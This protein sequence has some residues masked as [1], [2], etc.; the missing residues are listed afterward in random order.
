[1]AL[2]SSEGIGA[3]EKGMDGAAEA[4]LLA[5][6]EQHLRN[7]E[8]APATIINYIADVRKVL[9]WLSQTKGVSFPA[10]GLNSQDLRQ[11]CIYLLKVE[12]H[13]GT[14]VSRYLCSIGRFCRFVLAIGV[15]APNKGIRIE[16]PRQ[17]KHILP[18]ALNWEEVQRLLQAART[19][20]SISA[21]RDYAI[22]QVLLQTG[23]RVGE[24][25]DMRMG[26][27]CISERQARVSVNR[28]RGGEKREIPLNASACRA[29]SEYLAVRTPVPGVEHVFL[30]RDGRPFS[31]RSVQRIVSYY[32]GRAGL[33]GVSAKTL[34]YTCAKHLL[35]ETGDLALISRLLGYSRIESAARYGIWRRDDAAQVMENSSLNIF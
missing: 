31:T 35:E 24:L 21:E 33:D 32:A 20:S 22:M 1:M 17:P 7:A 19:E 6:F 12:E 18:R 4:K 2:S 23:M 30:T 26:D 13:T 25:S 16:L 5:E 29:L 10:C 15:A 3:N 9:R 27:V 11:Y 8:L 28:S 34:R 14:T